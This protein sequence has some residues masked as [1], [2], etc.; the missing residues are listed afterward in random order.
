MAGS[1][2][3]VAWSPESVTDVQG[4]FLRPQPSCPMPGSVLGPSDTAIGEMN[5]MFSVLHGVMWSL[6]CWTKMGPRDTTEHGP[7]WVNTFYFL[8]K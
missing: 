5:M 4:I 6:P 1:V 8:K 2:S 3:K 7:V